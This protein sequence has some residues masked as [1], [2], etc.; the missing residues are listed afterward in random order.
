MWENERER[1]KGIEKNMLTCEKELKKNWKWHIYPSSEEKRGEIE[2][3]ILT[4]NSSSHDYNSRKHWNQ[5]KLK[6]Y[7]ILYKNNQ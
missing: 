6:K 4:L 3:D 5:F 7:V 2:C 1:E